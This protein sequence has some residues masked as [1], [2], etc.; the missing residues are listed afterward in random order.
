MEELTDAVRNWVH[1]DNLN[2]NLAKQVTTARNMRNTY[3][4]K[5]L[6]LMGNTK[7][8]R[9]HGAVLEPAEKTNSIGLN[10]TTLEEALHKYFASEKK[11]DD[12][13][14]LLD[15]LKDN[16]GSKVTKFLKKIPDVPK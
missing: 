4:E 16:R 7:R 15:F 14:K 10:W 11:P 8:I 1:F 3:E 2:A 13:E 9:I 6:T 12:T 5:V